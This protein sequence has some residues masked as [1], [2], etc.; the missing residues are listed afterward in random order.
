MPTYQYKCD[1]CDFEFEEFQKIS[2]KPIKSCPKCEGKTRRLISGGA[3]FLLKGSGFYSTDY[4]SDSYKK[5][6]ALEMPAKAVEKKSETSKNSG[7]SSVKKIE[8]KPKD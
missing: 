8:K 7:E 3:G 1:D 4:R 6:A 5:M 2:D